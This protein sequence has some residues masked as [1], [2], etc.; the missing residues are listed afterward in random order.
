MPSNFALS[1]HSSRSPKSW[2]HKTLCYKKMA[3][4]N[5]LPTLPAYKKVYGEDESPDDVLPT[6]NRRQR[7]TWN[8][9]SLSS[10]LQI[11]LLSVLIVMV[12]FNLQHQPLP[13]FSKTARATGCGNTSETAKAAG[14]L[15]DPLSYEWTA[16]KCYDYETVAEFRTFLAKTPLQH[17]PYPFFRSNN[18]AD[19]VADEEEFSTRVGLRTFSTDEEHLIHCAF[20]LRR[21]ERAREGHFKWDRSGG[22]AHTAHCSNMLV[23]S[24]LNGKTTSDADSLHAVIDIGVIQEC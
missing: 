6:H 23:G 22:Y 16:P 2:R 14:C 15:F 20:M 18:T 12:Y 7:R 8:Y 1:E 9:T 21:L 11:I 5:A 13:P 24:I 19:R 17:G 3:F 10:L 4:N